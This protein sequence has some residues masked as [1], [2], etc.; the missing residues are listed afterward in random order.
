[1]SF[2]TKE[3]EACDDEKLCSLI[4]ED[5]EAVDR[6]AR[7]TTKQILKPLVEHAAEELAKTPRF[8]KD[9]A[10]ICAFLTK[11]MHK[12]VEREVRRYCPPEY[13][14][15][16]EPKN[17]LN[18]P[19]N[20][21]DEMM[22]LMEEASKDSF[23]LFHTARQKM[24]K[25]G[26][27]DRDNL[28]QMVIEAYGG[29]DAFNQRVA[30]WKEFVITISE[31]RQ[32]VDDRIKIDKFTKFLLKIQSFYLSKNRVADLNNISSKWMKTGVENQDELITIAKLIF[33]A[34]DRYSVIG[35]WFNRQI[36]RQEHGLDMEKMPLS[37]VTPEE[38]DKMTADFNRELME[39]ETPD[40]R[41]SAGLQIPQNRIVPNLH[42]TKPIFKRA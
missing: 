37:E 30:D 13:K 23:C 29:T 14:Q 31:Y 8:Q 41:T 15:K 4:A 20:A 39:T 25:L 27:E 16:Y 32:A 26:P 24:R 19:V 21:L 2:K 6:F 10:K 3:I 1:M 42:K 9:P 17:D 18:I 11:Y 34:D 12:N 38:Y 36:H 40:P 33:K 22:A 7:L 5:I 35:R 28:M